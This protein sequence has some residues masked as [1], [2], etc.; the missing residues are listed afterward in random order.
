MLHRTASPVSVRPDIPFRKH[1]PNLRTP[2]DAVSLRS[3]RSAQAALSPRRPHLR[4]RN[5]KPAL[6]LQSSTVPEK[7]HGTKRHVRKFFWAAVGAGAGGTAGSPAAVSA[8]IAR[9]PS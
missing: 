3:R 6:E 7:R 8:A 4:E 2:A 5:V 9:S 1:W